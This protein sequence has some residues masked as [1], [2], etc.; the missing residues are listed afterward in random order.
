MKS[1]K[2]LTAMGILMLSSAVSMSALDINVTWLEAGKPDSKQSFWVRDLDKEKS[3]QDL[4]N[5]IADQTGDFTMLLYAG[6]NLLNDPAKSLSE[7]N[8]HPEE[9]VFAIYSPSVDIKGW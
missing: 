7:A 3:V 5:I 9:N 1:K 8:L 4:Y 6:K 2:M